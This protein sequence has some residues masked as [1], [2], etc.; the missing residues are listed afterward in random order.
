MAANEVLNAIQI[1]VQ[2]RQDG[3]QVSNAF[4]KVLSATASRRQYQEKALR[5]RMLTKPIIQQLKKN[6]AMNRG[7]VLTER[8]E[9]SGLKRCENRCIES[10]D[11]HVL[12]FSRKA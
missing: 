5:L 1:G 8:S 12:L 9:M 2:V 10:S 11:Y 3:L 7:I 6:G 4:R